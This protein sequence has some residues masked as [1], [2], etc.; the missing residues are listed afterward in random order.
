MPNLF[1]HLQDH[2][3]DVATN[4][5]GYEASWTPSDQSVAQTARVMLK[6]PSEEVRHA[7]VEYDPENWVT[8]YKEGDFAELKNYVDKR[9]SRER[10][11]INGSDYWV[12]TVTKHHDGKTYR[13]QIKP[14]EE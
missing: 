13:A 1:D 6:N 14:I 12:K 11:T 5:A 8:E 2:V 7:G 10:L 3:F 4:F 9:N